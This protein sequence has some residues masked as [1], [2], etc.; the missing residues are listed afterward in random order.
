MNIVFGKGPVSTADIAGIARNN[1]VVEI[2]P[3]IYER[4][5]KARAVLDKVAASGQHI[6]GLNTGL[7]ANL[8]TSVSSD[9]TGF[10]QQLVRGRGMGVGASLSRELTRAVMAARLSMLTVGGSGIS[11][12]VFTDLLSL[13]NKQVH[14]V[15]PS[16][17]SI[18]AGDLVLLSALAQSLIG[19]GN[20]EYQGVIYPAAQALK[21]AELAP[22]QLGPKDGLSL[23]NASAVSVG[24]GALAVVDALALF[25]FQRQAAAL[26]FEGLGGNPLILT[27]ALQRARPASGQIEEAEKLAALLDGSALHKAKSAIQDPLSLRCIPSIHGALATALEAAK[28]AIEIELNAAADNPLV[29]IE[30]ER[31]LSTGNFHTPA[32]ALAFET[33]GLAIAQA[34]AAS[35]ARFIQ[36]TGSSRNGLPKYLTP[37]GSASAGF[38]PLQKT[39]VAL[40]AAIRHKANPVMLDFL[41]VSEGVEDHATQS[42]LAVSKCADM[43]DLWRQLVACELLAAAQAVDLK[44][45][46]ICGSGTSQIHHFVRD[47]SAQLVEDRALSDDLSKLVYSMIHR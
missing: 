19:E 17:G 28:H 36:L 10:Q 9:I 30:E 42:P 20:A 24:Q 29:I 6:Y 23:L 40:L 33:L 45:Q 14:P 5:A 4:L 32:L 27:P 43:I 37:V 46:H 15:M 1:A 44:P 8:K 7:G 41:P 16:I 13:L 47:L 21:L 3:E 31:V 11:P 2:A 39:V 34:A 38:I 26:S 22:S 35:A 18:G 25:D 12:V